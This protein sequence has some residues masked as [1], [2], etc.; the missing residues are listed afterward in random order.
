[1]SAFAGAVDLMFLDP[2]MAVDALYRE[3]GSGWGV[4]VRVIRRA[5]DQITEFGPGRFVHDAVLIDVRVSEVGC[6][7]LGDRFLIG[8]E[9]F[10][11]KGDPI[12]D[13]ERLVWRAEAVAL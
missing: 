10:E 13:S 11:V 6:L 7:S 1:M 12:R 9:L 3:G 4:P 2:Y 5:P 8:D